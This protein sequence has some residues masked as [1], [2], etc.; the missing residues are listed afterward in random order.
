VNLSVDQDIL[1]YF[2]EE[3]KEKSIKLF[4]MV[5]VLTAVIS[6]KNKLESSI[7]S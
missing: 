3:K 6:S 1:S 4:A 2:L 7:V 5:S